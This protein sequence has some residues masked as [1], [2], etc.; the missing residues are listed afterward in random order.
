VRTLGPGDF[1]GELALLVTDP[2]T[3]SVVT[4]VARCGSSC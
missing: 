3:A 2:R 4:D 1:F